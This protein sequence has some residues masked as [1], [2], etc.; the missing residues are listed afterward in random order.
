MSKSEVY[1]WRV[2]PELKSALEEAARAEQ[3]TVSK[4]L[5]GIVATWLEQ[6]DPQ[7]EE[8]AIQHR[9]HREAARTFGK[10][11]GGDP[12]RSERARDLVKKKLAGRRAG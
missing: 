9:L 8:A 3:T 11:R 2:S 4:L 1:S 5:D 12:R 6:T 7:G 10:I